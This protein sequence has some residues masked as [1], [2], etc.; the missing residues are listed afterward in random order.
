[1][2]LI[3]QAKQLGYASADGGKTWEQPMTFKWMKDQIARMCGFD[4][5][6]RVWKY[7]QRKKFSYESRGVWIEVK[8]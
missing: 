4:D 7:E 8:L 5:K 6:A 3:H 2:N 1:M